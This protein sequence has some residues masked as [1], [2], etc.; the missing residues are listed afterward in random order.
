M[1]GLVIGRGYVGMPLACRLAASGH[2]T[3][4]LGRSNEPHDELRF[5]GISN[6]V[7]DVTNPD[8]LQKIEPNFDA[9]VNL[10]S[11]TRGG[12]EEYNAVYKE[13]T[14]NILRWLQQHP[15]AK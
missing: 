1:R 15:P 9:I 4:A 11:S 10:V 13:G 5:R 2:E 8:S 12:P 14:R 3:F 6:L 7:A